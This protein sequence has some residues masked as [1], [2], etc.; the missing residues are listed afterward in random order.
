M[1]TKRLV[2]LIV[3]LL[4]LQLVFTLNI[5]VALANE[6]EQLE[7]IDKIFASDGTEGDYFGDSSAIYGD[8][9]VVGA[10][11]AGNGNSSGSVYVYNLSSENISESEIILTASDG[12]TYDNFGCSVAIYEDILVVGAYC[13][14]FE[15]QDLADDPAGAVYIYDL[16]ASSIAESEVQLIAS[17][18]ND[19]YAFGYKVAIF[20][21]K[22]AVCAVQ[23]SNT[24][25]VYVYD[26]TAMDINE[27][28]IMLTANDGEYTLGFGTDIA[29]YGDRLVIGSPYATVNN[30]THSTGAAYLYD[31]SATDINSSRITIAASDGSTSDTF[32]TSVALQ[33]DKLAVSS[34]PSERANAVH[35]YD[36]SSE[37]IAESEII[38]STNDFGHNMISTA[39]FDD[40]V[41]VG[42]PL[43]SSEDG[44][45]I[46]GAVYI[47]NLSEA[48]VAD[49]RIIFTE[50]DVVS[51]DMFG[52]TVSLSYDK[53]IIGA[54]K[55]ENTG[56]VY[57]YKWRQK[58]WW[59]TVRD[60]PIISIGLPIGAIIAITILYKILRKS[61]T[62]KTQ[63]DM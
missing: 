50:S 6:G 26:L 48:N 28:E 24:A 14:R 13:Y 29:I 25:A 63:L 3:T 34:D 8:I 27:S 4:I 43:T 46:T 44:T 21:D 62:S 38:L 41:V 35:V 49:S 17:N 57:L 53:L 7:Q 55:N 40:I 52:D 60:F 47:Y 39:I 10:P 18:I 45:E 30:E 37:N 36:L 58:T 15:D 5:E 19:Y 9:L 42:L 59:E 23:D 2:F 16:S 51:C 12:E 32:G 54:P 11:H 22:V 33:G 31:L 20:G 61:R 1:K 56:S